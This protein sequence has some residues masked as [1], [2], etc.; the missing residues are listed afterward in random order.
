MIKNER[1]SRHSRP[2]H[3]ADVPIPRASASRRYCAP[4]DEV[5]DRCVKPFYLKMMGFNALTCEEEVLRL[6]RQ[7]GAGLDAGAVVKLLRG[8]WRPRVM[9]AWY[10]L[11][12]DTHEVRQALLYSLETSAGT[13]TAP[14]L[15]TAAIAL[16]GIEAVPSLTAYAAADVSHQYGAAGFIAAAVERLG[17]AA[18]WSAPTDQDR[19]NVARM[20]AVAT[21]L[22]VP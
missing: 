11:L 1:T 8:E 16:A 19:D 5:D 18:E 3:G 13:L 20:Q 7:V 14:A 21:R 9:G 4:V 2:R 17:G 22:C 6:I 10:A 15:A 12:H